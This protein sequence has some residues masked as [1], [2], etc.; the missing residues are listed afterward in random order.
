MYRLETSFLIGVYVIKYFFFQVS[1]WFMAFCINDVRNEERPLANIRWKRLFKTSTFSYARRFLM[2][3]I[4]PA[5]DPIDMTKSDLASEWSR[6][7][8][9][10]FRF[11]E[12]TTYIDFKSNIKLSFMEKQMCKLAW[13]RRKQFILT[14]AGG[15]RKKFENVVK[16]FD[17]YFGAKNNFVMAKYA[18][19]KEKKKPGE[20]F[21]DYFQT[22]TEL[23]KKCQFGLLEQQLLITQVTLGHDDLS[24]HCWKKRIGNNYTFDG[25]LS[26]I[27]LHYRINGFPT[28]FSLVSLTSRKLQLFPFL[29]FFL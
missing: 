28:I 21:N 24:V 17:A 19:F 8:K 29:H 16:K 14:E 1:S 5:A 6:F 23:A 12:R 7:K 26:T 25:I 11:L 4:V 10:F 20:K 2:L 22:I 3:A 9:E 27:Y 15:K 13:S 18:F